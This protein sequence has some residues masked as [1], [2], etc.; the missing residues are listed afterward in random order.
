VSKSKAIVCDAGHN[1]D[2]F[3][4]FAA[5]RRSRTIGVFWISAPTGMVIADP[6]QRRS[7]SMKITLVV[8]GL[9]TSTMP[10]YAQD[11]TSAAK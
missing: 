11:Q 1:P 8:A 9:V 10:G 3:A 6:K 2:S 4:T 5:I 7:F